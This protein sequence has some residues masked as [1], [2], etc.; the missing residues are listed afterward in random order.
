MPTMIIAHRS[1]MVSPGSPAGP[2]R[3]IMTGGIG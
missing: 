2:A 3:R 1:R